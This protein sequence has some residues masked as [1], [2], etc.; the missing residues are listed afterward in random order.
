MHGLIVHVFVCK[1]NTRVW[2]PVF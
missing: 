1:D 2:C